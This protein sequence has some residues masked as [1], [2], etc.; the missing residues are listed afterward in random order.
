[1][2]KLADQH[3]SRTRKVLT[4]ELLLDLEDSLTA[5]AD[6]AFKMVRDHAGLRSRRARELEGQARFRMMEQRF[7]EVCGYHGGQPLQGGVILQTGMKVFQ[8]YTR[9]E[10]DS[11]GVILGMAAIPSPRELPAK[12]K[13]RLAGVALNYHLVPSLALDGQGA[14][15]GDIFA[16]LLIARD[17]QEG[18]KIHEMAVGLVDAGY[19]G[20]LFYESFAKFIS[21]QTEKPQVEPIQIKQPI[22]PK[23]VT[24]TLK[25]KV[26]PYVPPEAQTE[27]N[28]EI[29]NKE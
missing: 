3:K 8:P 21:E 15:V 2:H 12:N 23:M 24:P 28:S 9:F 22:T 4:R 20:Y 25:K 17:R 16:L 5:E 13:S 19:Q 26:T 14:Q 10:V 27:A 7:E 29:A 18:G 6:K 1:M 11:R